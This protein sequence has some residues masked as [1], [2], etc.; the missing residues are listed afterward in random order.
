MSHQHAVGSPGEA[1]PPGGPAPLG[2]PAASPAGSDPRPGG[3][4]WYTLFHT[5]GPFCGGTRMVWYLLHGDVVDAARMHLVALLG[6]PFVLYMPLSWTA[7]WVFERRLP[8]PHLRTWMYAAYIAAFVPYG[9]V[10]RNLPGFEWFHIA[11]MQPVLG[12]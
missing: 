5:N 11:Y 9:A 6:T 1:L 4:G 7:R 3:C 12:L 2:V 8:R 10:L